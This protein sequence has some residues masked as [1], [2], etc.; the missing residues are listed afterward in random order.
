MRYWPGTITLYFTQYH[1]G[2][3]PKQGKLYAFFARWGAAVLLCGGLYQRRAVWYTVH[4]KV[5]KSAGPLAFDVLPAVKCKWYTGGTGP[6][7]YTTMQVYLE[8]DTLCA[9]LLAFERQPES[10]SRLTL[11]LTGGGQHMLLLRLAPAECLTYLCG[12]S[13]VPDLWQRCP[14]APLAAPEWQ[15]VAGE[16]EQGWYWGA[17]VRLAP[18]VLAQAGLAPG[19]QGFS[20]ALFKHEAAGAAYGASV[21]PPHPQQPLDVGGFE[22]YE[23]VL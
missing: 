1:K 5:M 17:Q 18:Q 9:R 11:A 2:C 12:R 19:A 6:K 10:G 14:G 15:A 21:V 7:V 3:Q 20:A 16:D 23:I 13:P 22:A 8:K 4:M